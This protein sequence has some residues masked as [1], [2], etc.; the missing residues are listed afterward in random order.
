MAISID[1]RIAVLFETPNITFFVFQI[2]E[3]LLELCLRELF[4][5]RLMQT[6]P[7][8]ANFFYNPDTGKVGKMPYLHVI[9]M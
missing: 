2:G 9:L 7:N 5:F 4:E 6:D 1:H 3:K 8:W